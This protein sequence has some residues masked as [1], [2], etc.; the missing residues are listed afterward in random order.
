M[1]NL[2]IEQRLAA[3]EAENARLKAALDAKQEQEKRALSLS[4]SDK[5]CINLRGVRTFPIGF[6]PEEW[7]KML[8]F[9]D[10]ILK[11]A[12]ENA[13]ELARKNAE[14]KAKPPEVKERE[15][16]EAKA[17]F[18]ARAKRRYVG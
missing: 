18:E 6:Y 7:A 12:Q 5:G 13:K 4:I 16:A 9:G 11:F 17:K 14:Y 10:E 3:I 8:S 15:A 2:T 1:A